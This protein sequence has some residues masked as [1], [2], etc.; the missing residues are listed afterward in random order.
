VNSTDLGAVKAGLRPNTRWVWLETPTNPRLR[1]ADLR[2]IA[3][4]AHA[5][6][7]SCA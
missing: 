7:P 4:A 6:A 1:L 2:A 3:Q 5:P